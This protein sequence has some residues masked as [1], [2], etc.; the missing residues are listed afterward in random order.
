MLNWTNFDRLAFA[1]LSSM[2]QKINLPTEVMLHSLQ[3]KKGLELVFG[4][5]VL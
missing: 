5:Q 1:Y 2:L 3:T 4:S